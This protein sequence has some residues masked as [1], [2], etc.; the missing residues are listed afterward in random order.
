MAARHDP[1]SALV[2]SESFYISP[3]APNVRT[4][5]GHIKISL[6]DA[7][8]AGMLCQWSFNMAV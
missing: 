3:S 2:Q 8:S 5:N 1:K 7:A 6:G 4:L